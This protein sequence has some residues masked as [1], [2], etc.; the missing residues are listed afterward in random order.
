MARIP[1][2]LPRP[3]RPFFFFSLSFTSCQSGQAALPFDERKSLLNY[4]FQKGGAVG[5]SIS[6][7]TPRLPAKMQALFN[8]NDISQQ[9]HGPSVKGSEHNNNTKNLTEETLGYKLLH[10]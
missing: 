4:D 7:A 3:Q 8:R 6:R 10:R 2:G 9:Q 5:L 1:L